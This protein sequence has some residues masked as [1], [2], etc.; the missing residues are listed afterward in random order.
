MTFE[1]GLK[2]TIAARKRLTGAVQT[3]VDDVILRTDFTR[4]AGE[5]LAERAQALLP[6]PGRGS[7]LPDDLA[8]QVG[9]RVQVYDKSA[10]YAEKALAEGGEALV[11]ALEDIPVR[12]RADVAKMARD[13]FDFVAGTGR[14]N[15]GQ[16]LAYGY[17]L[18]NLPVQVGRVLQMG[19]IPAVTIGARN[20]LQAFDRA[21]QRAVSA[22]TR[23]RVLGGGLTTPDGTYL[24]PKALDGLADE[25]GLGLTQ[26]ETE[27]VG[28]LAS[29]LIRS[30]KRQ[31]R[32]ME[33]P[34]NADLL[35]A[36]EEADPFSRGF[37]L[38]AAESMELNFRKS[39]F[40]M[41][42]ARGDA[43]QDAAELAR[44]SQLNFQDVPDA[45]Q[46]WLGRYIG[47]SAFLYRA[48]AEAVLALAESPTR[49]AR[50]LRTLR[51][52]AEIQDPY[53]V[54][55][56]KAL[57]SL[58]M[59]PK[60]DGEVYYLPEMPALQPVEAAI[61]TVRA[62]DNLIADIIFATNQSAGVLNALEDQTVDWK[63]GVQLGGEVIMP[64]V[65]RAFERF[66]EGQEYKTT[67][68]PDAKPLSDEQAFWAWMI[69]ANNRD[70]EHANGEWAAFTT[71]APVEQ[72]QPPPDKASRE[73]PGAWTAQPPDGIPHVLVDT[74]DG[75]PVYFAA[76]P[77]PQALQNIRFARTMDVG[78]LDNLLP[79][80]A[81]LSERDRG[82][83]PVSV[84][85]EGRLPS[86]LTEAAG[87]ALLG[88][89]PADVQRELE[90]Q[91]ETVRDIREGIEI[92]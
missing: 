60:A 18:P 40:E 74:I 84:F 33:D 41:A 39:V 1:N 21:G 49:A 92:Q 35:L 16:R 85:A 69:I 13:A 80:Y 7:V 44:N 63:T 23:R 59:V 61:G 79:F 5:T 83:A 38:R 70:P 81:L 82:T 37:F 66:K 19:I 2:K 52:K 64:A 15:I 76:K 36:L 28:S 72:V 55:G 65:L 73:V 30:A 54:H 78:G 32:K 10:G 75:Q 68:V 90:R 89:G 8:R 53:N 58:G 31:A 43:P 71:L 87:E 17:I 25:Y 6:L 48:G 91:A 11:A 50:V 42:L 20:A 88:S 14:R 27:R 3:A 12:E 67:D 9:N 4:A 24:S 45:V 46:T 26:L 77:T 62:A 57:K 22:L 34:D 29:D 86:T 51:A 56:D 47:E